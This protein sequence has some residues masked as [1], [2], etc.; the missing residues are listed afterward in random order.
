MLLLGLSAVWMAFAALIYFGPAPLLPGFPIPPGV[1]AGICAVPLLLAVLW[2]RP[3]VPQR[4]MATSTDEFWKNPL[5]STGAALV[6]FLTEGSAML[7][8][9]WTLLT[10]DWLCVIVSALAI[11]AMAYHGPA[12]YERVAL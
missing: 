11:A 10:G 4:N 2:A 3:R 1:A 7:S 12:H 9:V 8:A 5:V 6:L